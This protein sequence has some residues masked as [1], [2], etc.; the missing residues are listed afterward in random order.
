MIYNIQ[1]YISYSVLLMFPILLDKQL[2]KLFILV[3]HMYI[4]IQQ[5]NKISTV[6]IADT[7]DVSRVIFAD[8]Y[9]I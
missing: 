9:T 1:N 2:F 4:F 3:W 6:E 7:L 8:L 5:T